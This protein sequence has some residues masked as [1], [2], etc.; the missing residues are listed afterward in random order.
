[1]Y[2]KK[3]MLVFDDPDIYTYFIPMIGSL[4]AGQKGDRLSVCRSAVSAACDQ[5]RS[6]LPFDSVVFLSAFTVKV[7]KKLATSVT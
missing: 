6:R 3:S 4:C 2:N 1:M 7:T 5:V